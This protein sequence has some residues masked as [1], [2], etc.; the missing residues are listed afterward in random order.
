M[1]KNIYNK[2]ILGLGLFV[3][4]MGGVQEAAA[5]ERATLLERAAQDPACQAWVDST[6][7]E[8]PLK[9]RLTQLFIYKCEVKTDAKSMRLLRRVIKDYKVGGLLFTGGKML[10]QAEIMNEAQMMS[11][12]PLMMTFDGEWGL[13]MRLKEAP[14][15]PRNGEL[16]H[17]QDNQLIYEYGKEVARECRELGIHVNFAPDADVNTNPNNPVIG[18]RSF[19]SDPENVAEKVIAYSRGLE[20]GGVIS[21]AKHF[22][23]HGDTHQDSHKTLPLLDVTRARLDSVEL[24]PFKEYINR[25][26]NGVMVGHLEVP[27]LEPKKGVPS[28][29]SNNIVTGLLQEEMGFKGLVFTDALEMKGAGKVGEKCLRA[30]QA[31]NDMLL[32]PRILRKEYERVLKGIKNGELSEEEITR[33]CRKVLTYKY[34]LG[35]NKKPQRALMGMERRINSK[36]AH[37]LIQRLYEAATDGELAKLT[38]KHVSADIDNHAWTSLDSLLQDGITK[39]A[40]PG[41]Q[42][43]ILKDGAPVYDKCFGTYTYRKLKP[44]TDEAIYDIASVTKTSATLLAVMKLYDEGKINLADRVAKYLLWM[45]NDNTGKIKIKDLLFHESGLRPSIDVA[46]ILIDHHSYDGRLYQRYCSAQYPT[47]VWDRKY[48]QKHYELSGN[49]VSGKKEGKYTLPVTKNM[50]ANTLMMDSVKHRIAD[51]PLKAHRYKYSCVN[52]IVL[53]Q[54][55]EA[56]TGQSMNEY[57]AENFYIPMGLAHTMYRPYEYYPIEQI[58][59]T[60]KDKLLRGSLVHGYV[61]DETAAF[62]GGIS[63]NAGLFST[64]HDLGRLYQMLLNGGELDGKR[65]LSRGTI[66]VFSKTRSS[67]SRRGLGFDRPE[68]V[69]NKRGPLPES[70]P[71]SLYGHLG[72]TGTCAWV[73]PTNDMVFV[74]LS[75]RIYTDPC[76]RKLITINVRDKIFDTVYKNK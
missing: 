64:A 57:L 22:P 4:S 51:Q 66:S 58:V 6:I 74:F 63:G 14:H 73:D 61:H 5:Q 26:L 40:F 62:L 56:I 17:I 11:E 70:A 55:V 12:I 34:M 36:D 24:Y 60:A 65:Y 37:E 46:D 7:Q 30:L 29:M 59:P 41:C 9:E 47:K 32:V 38:S 54:M 35:L 42:L 8:M 20:D 28:S 48:V 53:W 16:E 31:G 19:G 21:V 68:P 43:L 1:I 15:F 71:R 69:Y 23:G 27:V 44:V 52:F 45:D 33:R 25:G 76:N 2:T 13:A 39:K 49:L 3:A 75:N 10:T 72:F 67:I 50:W 18:N